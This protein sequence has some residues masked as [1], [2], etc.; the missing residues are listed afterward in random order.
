[1]ASSVKQGVCL[2]LCTAL[3]SP[4]MEL[5]LIRTWALPDETVLLNQYRQD[6]MQD[7]MSL[8]FSDAEAIRNKNTLILV[9]EDR[10]PQ[11]ESNSYWRKGRSSTALQG[12]EYVLQWK[13][14]IPNPSEH[15]KLTSTTPSHLQ[16]PT[17][18][19]LS[20]SR[21]RHHFLSALSSVWKAS[22]G[23]P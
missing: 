15:R 14:A 22:S 13:G 4:K 3:R 17:A 1:M 20:M 16:F 12:A 5:N 6:P 9:L 19:T 23:L 8:L 18:C 11:W 7:F 2:A 10:P 21:P